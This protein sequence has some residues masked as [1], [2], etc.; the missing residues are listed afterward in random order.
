MDIQT[1]QYSSRDLVAAFM[2]IILGSGYE[3]FDIEQ[4]VENFPSS[5]TYLL[6]PTYAFNNLFSDF[7][8]TLFGCELE[9]L[10][11]YIQYASTY[12]ALELSFEL[13]RAVNADY[14]RTVR[15]NYFCFKFFR[16]ILRIS[17]PIRLST[18]IVWNT[19]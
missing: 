5:S 13:P 18:R 15:V 8:K 14:N 19:C 4:I 1:L 11:P 2:Y 3:Q 16:A 10:L 6:D 9:P 12:F 7:M 17:W